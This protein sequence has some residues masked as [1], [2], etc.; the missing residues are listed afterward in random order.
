VVSLELTGGFVYVGPF[1]RNQDQVVFGVSSVRVG[2]ALGTAGALAPQ[3]RFHGY[4]TVMLS[5]QALVLP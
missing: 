1:G 2:Q 3:Y 5:Y 4:E